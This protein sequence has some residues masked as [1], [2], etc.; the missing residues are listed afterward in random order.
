MWPQDEVE[1]CL[2]SVWLCQLIG[3][4]VRRGSWKLCVHA[5]CLLYALYEDLKDQMTLKSKGPTPS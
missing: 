3:H 4:V 2:L 5:A 1:P